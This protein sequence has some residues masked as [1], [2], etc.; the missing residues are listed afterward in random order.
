MF[1]DETLYA[2]ASERPLTE[3]ELLDIKGIGPVK[4]ERYGAAVLELITA[5]LED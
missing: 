3:N 5:A 1:T 4:V 2:L